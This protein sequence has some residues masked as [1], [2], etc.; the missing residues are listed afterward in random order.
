[1]FLKDSNLSSGFIIGATEANFGNISYDLLIKE[2]ITD[3]G[4]FTE[5]NLK[6]NESVFVST[7]EVVDVPTDMFA[8]V[9]IRNSAIRLGLVISAPIYQPGHK[10]R[11]FFRATNISRVAITLKQET[12][13]CSLMVYH[14]NESS[15][16]PYSGVYADEFDYRGVGDFH[17]VQ[18]PT[19]GVLEEKIKDLEKLEHRLY[20]NVMMMLTVFVAIFSLVNLNMSTLRNGYSLYD[21]IGFNA[22]FLGVISALVILIAEIIGSLQKRRRLLWVVPLI[23]LSVSCFLLTR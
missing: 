18:V 14:F 6:P 22:M 23:A 7:I 13:V 4:H 3:A 20:S 9:V 16:R 12:S 11:I 2:I 8:Q 5:Y 10:T 21:I 17:S 19:V 1:M 15:S